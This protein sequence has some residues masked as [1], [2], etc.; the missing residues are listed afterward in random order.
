[1]NFEQYDPLA[2]LEPVYEPEPE[3]IAVP[4]AL[5]FALLIFFAFWAGIAM[6]LVDPASARTHPYVKFAEIDQPDDYKTFCGCDDGGAFCIHA[7]L[8][9]S[10]VQFQ[11]MPRDMCVAGVFQGVDAAKGE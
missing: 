3:P 8:K 5:M 11:A 6:A 1:M 2:D 10:R 9:T 4:V 7:D